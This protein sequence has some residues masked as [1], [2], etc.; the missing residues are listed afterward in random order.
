MSTK[1]QAYMLLWAAGR[2]SEEE[3][4]TLQSFVSAYR[5]A[6][7]ASGAV[8]GEVRRI[9]R[10]LLPDEHMEPRPVGNVV[11]AWFVTVWRL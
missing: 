4:D 9:S 8:A 3:V 7:E 1:Q 2:W 11:G 6:L 5:Q 10:S